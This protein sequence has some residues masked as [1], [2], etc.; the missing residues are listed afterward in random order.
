LRNLLKI[1]ENFDITEAEFEKLKYDEEYLENEKILKF[2]EDYLLEKEKYCQLNQRTQSPESK[3]LRTPAPEPELEKLENPLN[4]IDNMELAAD[5]INPIINVNL[6]L[7]LKEKEKEKQKQKQKQEE[8]DDLAIIEIEEEEE[9]IELSKD[10]EKTRLVISGWKEDYRSQ[11]PEPIL[12]S[13]L[14][15]PTAQEIEAQIQSPIGMTKKT[16]ML[17]PPKSKPPTLK[18]K[19]RVIKF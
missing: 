6:N 1:S 12:I 11:N 3:P 10:E 14:D 15:K 2:P 4:C 18:L 19:T 16:A 9:K 17:L 8:D 5:N 7:N 13:P